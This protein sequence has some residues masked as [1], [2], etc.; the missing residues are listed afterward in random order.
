MAPARPLSLLLMGLACGLG[1]G[2]LLV[3]L[4]LTRMGDV[5][6]ALACRAGDEAAIA[7]LEK[8]NLQSGSRLAVEW[9]LVTA[10]AASLLV[11]SVTGFGM[12]RL[13][14]G[15]RFSAVACTFCAIPLAVYHTVFRLT[16]LQVVGEPAQVRPMLLDAGV[17]LLSINLCGTVFLPDVLRVLKASRPSRPEAAVS[18]TSS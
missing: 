2:A 9:G 1:A 11:I 15:S 12:A 8:Q 3:L 18:A 6:T 5:S 17:I 4:V 7:L 10:Q 14:W 16:E 13:W